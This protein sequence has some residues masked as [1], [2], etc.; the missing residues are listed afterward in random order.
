MSFQ[1]CYWLP[2]VFSNEK[3]K[4]KLEF[5][6][7]HIETNKLECFICKFKLGSSLIISNPD[8]KKILN[9]A[10]ARRRAKIKNLTTTKSAECHTNAFGSWHLHPEHK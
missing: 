5:P 6:C 3:K 1:M 10:N 9:H 7:H 8:G 2:I 4:V